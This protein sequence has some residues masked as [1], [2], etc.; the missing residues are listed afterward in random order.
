MM[1]R[2]EAEAMW[3]GL[4]DAMNAQW[5]RAVHTHCAECGF[6]DFDNGDPRCG[7][8]GF[9][10]TCHDDECEILALARRNTVHWYKVQADGCECQCSAR[11][12]L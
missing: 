11:Q 2:D 3:D 4:R 6:E 9:D 8:C 5:E 1:S 7:N 12:M 10:P